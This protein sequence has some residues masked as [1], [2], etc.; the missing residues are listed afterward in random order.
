MVGGLTQAHA[1]NAACSGTG[2]DE[3]TRP[4]I[5]CTAITE[6]MLV[7]MRFAPKG[8]V[9]RTMNASGRRVSADQWHF[10]SNDRTGGGYV[11]FH[12]DREHVTI[13]DASVDGANGGIDYIWNATSGGC[14]DFP[15]S[16]I[17]CSR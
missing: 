8:Y 2:K 5:S 15:G 1:E 16:Q 3:P 11:N 12:F 4:D 9:E 17:R 7:R 10:I 14:S 13:I 6:K